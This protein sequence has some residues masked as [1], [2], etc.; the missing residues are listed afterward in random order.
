MTFPDVRTSRVRTT[1]ACPTQYEGK[2]PDGRVYYFRYRSGVARLGLGR[3][4]EEAVADAMGRRGIVLGDG[5]DGVCS[6]DEFEAAAGELL[7]L[8]SP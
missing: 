1:P 5:L 3:T 2:M 7:A 4:N 8:R 6:E